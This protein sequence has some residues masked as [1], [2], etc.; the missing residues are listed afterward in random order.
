VGFD[1]ERPHE[2]QAALGIWEDPHDISPAADF[3]VEAFKHV[4]RLQ[5]L[6]MLTWQPEEGQRL[7]DRLLDPTGQTRIAGR[8]FG[9]PGRKISLRLIKVAPIIEPSQLLQA[10]VTMLAWQVIERVPKEMNVTALPGGLRDHLADR[11]DETGMIVGDHQFDAPQAASFQPDEEVLPGRAALAA[12]YLDRQNLP[13][14][15]PVD[16]NGDQHRLAH[17]DAGLAHL[18]IAGIED[19]V[20][21]GLLK[22]AFG[23]GLQAFVQPLVNR[24]DR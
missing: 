10:V 24:R 14:S 11:R 22:R 15:V 19:Q 21:K 12:G 17:H 6:V 3:L 20:S 18:L 4:G 7:F 1:C 13:P 16:A 2:A 9:K 5:V 8:P 23:K